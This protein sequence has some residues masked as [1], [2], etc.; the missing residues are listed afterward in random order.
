MKFGG[1]RLRV[2]SSR[3]DADARLVSRMHFICLLSRQAGAKTVHSG[4]LFPEVAR[5]VEEKRL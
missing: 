4:L 5:G 3:A 2:R 1:S